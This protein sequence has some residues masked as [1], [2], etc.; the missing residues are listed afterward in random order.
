[1]WAHWLGLGHSRRASWLHRAARQVM[2]AGGEVPGTLEQLRR[3]PGIGDYTAAAVASIAFGV[4]E[5]ALDGNVER[6]IARLL[7]LEGNPRAAQQRRRLLA[8]ARQL[9]VPGAPGDSNQALM[10]LGARVCLP[11][12][13]RCEGCPLASGC[14]AGRR[15]SAE[16]HP[17]PRTRRAP[18]RLRLTVAVVSAEDGGV[19]LFRRSEQEPLLAG[20]WELPWARA[21]SVAG[22]ARELG[23]RYGGDWR[24]GA[25]LGRLRHSITFRR[26]EV[27]VRTAWVDPHEEVAGGGDA[28]WF[29][30][31]ARSRLALSS[32]VKKALRLGGLEGRRL[33]RP[34]LTA[35]EDEPADQLVVD[36]AQALGD[37]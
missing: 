5:P 12:R 11:R 34:A 25:E 10:E 1:L 2:A 19:L 32:L 29:D 37:Q 7:A 8:A 17:P 35:G 27:A 30:A 16:R 23:E 15:G 31:E 26:L 24:L 14:Q 36:L 18:E 20:S 4:A 22:G 3:L 13:P 33:E 9:L 21:A 28:G 6:V